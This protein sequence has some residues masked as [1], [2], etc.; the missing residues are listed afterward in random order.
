LIF[1]YATDLTIHYLK[2]IMMVCQSAL[3]K[4]LAG[5]S[6]VLVHKQ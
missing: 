6:G 2:L 5:E 3:L 1:S 4:L